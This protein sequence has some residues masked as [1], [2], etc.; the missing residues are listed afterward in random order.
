MLPICIVCHADC[1]PSG[2]VCTYFDKHKIQ[3]IKINAIKDDLKS[4]DLTA[5]GGLV[6]M[7]GPYS[8]YDE[9]PWLEDEFQ[10]IQEAINKDISIMGVCFG[11][12]LVSKILGAEVYK[13]DQMETGWHMIKTDVSKLD[14]LHPLNLQKNFEVFEWHEDVFTIP[15]GATPIFSGINHE[16]Q[17]YLL[18]K[19]FVM[20]FHMEM[21]EHMVNDWLGKYQR[22]MPEISQ[23][24]QSSQQ[25]TERLTERLENLHKNADIIYDW[26]LKL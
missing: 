12:Q 13:A 26:W 2:Y 5:L 3:Y 10:L 21:T 22:C 18:G 9:L 8:V 6:F 23:S 20:Q 11:A 14:H 4:L 15:D 25:M 1:A 7:G 16:N 17:G 24:V 19:I